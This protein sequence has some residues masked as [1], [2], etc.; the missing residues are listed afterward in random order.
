MKYFSLILLA[1]N[2]FHNVLNFWESRSLHYIAIGYLSD[3]IGYYRIFL[4]RR[5]VHLLYK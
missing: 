5:L 1:T 3:I 4:R 2:T